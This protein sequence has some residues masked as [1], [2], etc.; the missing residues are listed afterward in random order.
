MYYDTNEATMTNKCTS[1]TG[2]FD[3]HG[4]APEQHRRHCL[5]GHVQG[6][7]GSHWM[8]PSGDYSLRIIP[9]AARATANKTTTKKCTKKTGHFDGRG[10]A[11]VQYP[12]HRPIEEV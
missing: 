8:P 10:G 7:S 4:G 3:G 11:L 6:Y 2:R 9:A 5:M 12:V 1:S